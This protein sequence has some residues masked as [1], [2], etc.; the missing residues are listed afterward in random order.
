MRGAEVLGLQLK[1]KRRRK[2]A[3]G[4]RRRWRPGRREPLRMLKWRTLAHALSRRKVATSSAV[5]GRSARGRAISQRLRLAAL[6]VGKRLS[7]FPCVLA[8]GERSPVPE[9][10]ALSF[11]SVAT[12]SSNRPSSPCGGNTRGPRPDPPRQGQENANVGQIL[13]GP[14]GSALMAATFIAVRC[15]GL[16]PGPT[17]QQTRAPPAPSEELSLVS[18]RT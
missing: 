13:E 15:S 8:A 17:G 10:G 9:P 6:R 14:R 11:Q 18:P 2:S 7:S 4:E 12:S 5:T 3:G 1:R 16:A